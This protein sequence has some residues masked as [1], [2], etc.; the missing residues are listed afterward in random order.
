[1][2]DLSAQSQ[3][4]AI[5][6]SRTP[7]DPMLDKVPAEL[8]SK[9]FTFTGRHYLELEEGSR[10][11][12]IIVRRTRTAKLLELNQR[13]RKENIQNHYYSGVVV[14]RTPEMMERFFSPN[15]IFNTTDSSVQYRPNQVDAICLALDLSAQATIPHPR[16][17]LSERDDHLASLQG[18]R[19]AWRGMFKRIATDQR[20]R[21]RLARLR[22]EV[23]DFDDGDIGDVYGWVLGMVRNLLY[24]MIVR[25][26]IMS[27]SRAIFFVK[28]VNR[29]EKYHTVV[30]LKRRD[31]L[32]HE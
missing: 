2:S 6:D 32:F 11:N 8:R 9:V 20:L 13:L 31:G 23:F 19:S 30:T 10:T 4:M 7:G 14:F 18:L 16:D 25:I 1:M 5:N 12:E 27:S 29:A 15:T 26:W 24:D 21:R 28:G 17:R 3:A 22:I